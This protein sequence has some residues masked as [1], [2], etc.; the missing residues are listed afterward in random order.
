MV[1]HTDLP[2]DFTLVSTGHQ[3]LQSILMGALKTNIKTENE[4]TL[5]AGWNLRHTKNI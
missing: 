1:L 2:K 3:K 5:Y 4:T